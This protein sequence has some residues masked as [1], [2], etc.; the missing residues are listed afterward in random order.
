MAGVGGE[1]EREEAEAIAGM[2]VAT[3][4][5]PHPATWVD[6]MQA[7]CSSAAVEGLF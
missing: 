5:A 1:I 6:W 7:R 4:R 3:G 2:M